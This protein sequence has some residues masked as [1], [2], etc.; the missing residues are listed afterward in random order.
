MTKIVG[1]AMTTKLEK[2]DYQQLI[3]MYPTLRSYINKCY[4]YQT[5]DELIDFIFALETNDAARD[6]K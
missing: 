4:Q 5:G 1:G 2:F 3:L 6:Y